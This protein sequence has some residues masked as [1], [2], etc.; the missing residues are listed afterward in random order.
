MASNK[1][2]K[3][4]HKHGTFEAYKLPILIL[5]GVV[6][7][8]IAG[9]I[10]GHKAVVV[11]P[12]GD[13]FLYMMFTL[14]IP[15]ILCLV[16]TSV[17]HIA[18]LRKLGKLIGVTLVVFIILGL[19]AS[20]IMVG[21]CAIFS[22]TKG[23]AISLPS[24][25]EVHPFSAGESIVKAFFVPD[26]VDILSKDHVL[27]AIIFSILVGISMSMMGK[28]AEPIVDILTRMSD[29]LLKLVTILMWYAPIGLGA[30][31]A[32][33][34]GDFGPSL[35]GS[36]GRAMLLYYPLTIAYW[37]IVY[38]I[39]SWLSAGSTGFKKWWKWI[40]APAVTAFGTCSS[41]ATLPVNLDAAKKIGI[42]KYIRE[43]ILPLGATIH[44]DGSCLS[45][46]LKIAFSF[47]ILGL[48]FFHAG[49]VAMAILIAILG[50][51][52]LSGIPGGGYMASI[53][54]VSIYGFPKEVLPVI[55][56]I[57]TLVDPPA[58]MVNAT[59]D[60]NAS[61]IATRVL[62]GKNWFTKVVD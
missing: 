59:G 28:R 51:V 21:G 27:P 26:F 60:T 35:L 7:G 38:S 44:M 1:K 29:V 62:E 16:T 48:P 41:T 23:V 61:M 37:V 34:I 45:G 9:A 47:G 19:I 8:S 32:Y 39:T 56:M 50:G 11:K 13:V 5:I 54:I 22:P 31:F 24:T 43:L 58:T 49:T 10:A 53:L 20:L 36:Y 14:V 2:P 25:V 18:D 33:L 30:Y 17:A 6:I 42:P 15:I 55:M 12:L 3:E 57:G 40:P 52:A 4:V 46:I